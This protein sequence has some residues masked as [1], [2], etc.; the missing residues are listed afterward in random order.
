MKYHVT[1]PTRFNRPTLMPLV[2]E[3]QQIARVVIVHTEPH[4]APIRGTTAITS[5]S[6]SIQAWWNAGLNACHGPTL[7]LNDDVVATADDLLALFAAL[8]DADLVYLAG[9]RVGHATPLTGWCYGLHPDRIRP[10]EAFQWWYG[11]DDLYKRAVR[12]G[13][14]VE[15]VDV[16]GI[17]HERLPVAFENP[18]HAAMVEQDAALFAKRWP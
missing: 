6:N 11:D 8:E 14:K 9:H 4:H 1:I 12:D 13:L 15:A 17:R 3:A 10:D 18:V 16:P 5:D 7:V 2:A